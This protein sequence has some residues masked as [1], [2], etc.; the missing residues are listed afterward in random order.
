MYRAYI[1]KQKTD[2]TWTSP[3]EIHNLIIKKSKYTN[4]HTKIMT[5]D[6]DRVKRGKTPGCSE[7]TQKGNLIW[8]GELAPRKQHCH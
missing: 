3:F 7:G 6:L 2:K 8:P 5:T 1:T 4:N